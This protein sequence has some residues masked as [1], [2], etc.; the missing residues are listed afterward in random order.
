LSS[1]AGCNEDR[2][3]S[4]YIAWV[5]KSLNGFGNRLKITGVLDRPTINAINQFKARNGVPPKQY[6]ASP[7]IEQALVKAGAS[8]PPPVRKLPCGPTS[9][10]QL[11]PLLR[12]Y[13]SDIPPEYLLGW[14]TVETGGKLGDLTR[15]CE[16]GYFQVHPEEAQELGISDF[17]RLSTDPAYSIEGG[18]KLVRKYAAGAKRAVS[19]FN[20]NPQG[21]MF[22]GLAKLQHWIPSA[23]PRILAQMRRDAVPVTDWQSIHDYVY[24]K[25]NLGFGAFNPRE[26]VDS[27]SHYLAS[28]ARWR[29]ILGAGAPISNVPAPATPSMGNTAFS[30]FEVAAVRAAI[31]QGQRDVNKLTDLLFNR[32]HPERQ[33]KPLQPQQTGLVNEWLDI[34][35]HLVLPALQAAA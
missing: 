34:Q 15:I 21:D 31:Q 16:R 17:D 8:A 27:V 28:V 32:R 33:A 29:K 6:Y 18:I 12:Q 23:P 5:Q 14:I 25:S 19:Q 22:W 11:L 30:P 10:A 4:T 24:S 1:P 2:C 9:T 3:T 35:A 26:G 13:A 7:L 20:L